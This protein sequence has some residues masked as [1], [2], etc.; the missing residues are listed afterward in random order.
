MGTAATSLQS[1]TWLECSDS[2]RARNNCCTKTPQH[3]VHVAAMG[4]G[5]RPWGHPTIPSCRHRY[6]ESGRARTPGCSP[7]ALPQSYR[8]DTVPARSG[9]TPQQLAH[10]STHCFL[11]CQEYHRP[12]DVTM[13][14]HEDV[15]PWLHIRRN[16]VL[17]TGPFCAARGSRCVALPNGTW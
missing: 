3:R 12:A 9:W 8:F 14:P 1:K 11:A 6:W 16:A 5:V 4:V 2:R 15:L 13:R 10:T 7:K 17:V